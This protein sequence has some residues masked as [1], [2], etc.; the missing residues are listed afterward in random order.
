M[1]Y[2]CVALYVL[3]TFYIHVLCLETTM[4]NHIPLPLNQ[5]TDRLSSPLALKQ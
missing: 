2:V 1:Y 3:H 5:A 4:F